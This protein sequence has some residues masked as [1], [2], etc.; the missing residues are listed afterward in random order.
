MALEGYLLDKEEGMWRK[1]VV[2]KYGQGNH[3]W[4][5]KEVQSLLMGFGVWKGIRKRWEL[6]KRFI[7]FDVGNGDSVRFWR[8]RWSGDVELWRVFPSLF[9]IAVNKEELISSV[10]SWNP[11][12]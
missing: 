4:F 10:R 1:V 8:D 3:L 9:N 11:H 5:P 7:R 2:G 6:F 12:F